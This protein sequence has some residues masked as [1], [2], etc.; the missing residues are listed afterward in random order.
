MKAWPAGAV[1]L[2]AIANA[3]A[4]KPAPWLYDQDRSATGF[5]G[6]AFK[7]SA[8]IVWAR[9]VSVQ[10]DTD[11]PGRP[12]ITHAKLRVRE[13]FKGPRLESV[14]RVVR[15]MTTCVEQP[16]NEGEERL[17]LLYYHDEPYYSPAGY[18]E[19]HAWRLSHVPEDQL[20]LPELRKL[21]DVKR[22][23]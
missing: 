14:H 3:Y 17:F 8:A 16:W 18:Y 22:A 11:T 20:L 5:A 19:L 1:L 9:I 23:P 7:N 15:D 13:Q 2:L 6:R 21:R 12:V 4:C 10:T